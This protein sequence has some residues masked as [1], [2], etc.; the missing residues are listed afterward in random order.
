MILLARMA[1]DSAYA[2]KGI[3]KSLLLHA[4]TRAELAAREIGGRGIMVD[5]VDEDAAGFY[6]RW[7]FKRMPGN[8]LLLIMQMDVVRASLAAA[9]QAAA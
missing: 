6:L 3:G 9:I 5:A 4:M 1:V 8:P 7:K 2:G